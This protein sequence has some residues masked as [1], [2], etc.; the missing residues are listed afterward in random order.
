MKVSGSIVHSENAIPDLQA[1][2]FEGVNPKSGSLT[3]N[4]WKGSTLSDFMVARKLSERK[5]QA[6]HARPE[7]G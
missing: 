4:G 1:S 5:H 2:T 7:I 6:S 3:Y